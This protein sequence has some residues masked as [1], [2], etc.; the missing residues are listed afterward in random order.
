MEWANDGDSLGSRTLI[1]LFES[2]NC[3]C[4]MSWFIICEERVPFYLCL[5]REKELCVAYHQTTRSLIGR[6]LRGGNER[7]WEYRST[8]KLM[9][10]LADCCQRYDSSPVRSLTES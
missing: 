2:K 8:E 5:L 6:L 7:V 4:V 10:S 9:P 1:V 3:Y